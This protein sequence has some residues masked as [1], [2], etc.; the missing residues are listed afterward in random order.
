MEQEVNFQSTRTSNSGS[1]GSSNNSGGGGGGGS[2]MMFAPQRQT[3]IFDSKYHSG[4]RDHE[5][6]RDSS[7]SPRPY[8][9]PHR[10]PT[11]DHS[12]SDHDMSSRRDRREYSAGSSS[13]NGPATVVHSAPSKH[14][15]TTMSLNGSYSSPSVSST[16]TPSTMSPMH[17][18]LLLNPDIKKEDDYRLRAPDVD[19]KGHQDDQHRRRD[20]ERERERDGSGSRGGERDSYR[21]ERRDKDRESRGRERERQDDRQDDRRRM[22]SVLSAKSEV[23]SPSIMPGSLSPSLFRQEKKSDSVPLLSPL[24]LKENSSES[25][26][27]EALTKHYNQKLEAMQN[28]IA[29]KDVLLTKYRKTLLKLFEDKGNAEESEGDNRSAISRSPSR[30]PSSSPSRSSSESRYSDSDMSDRE[31]RPRKKSLPGAIMSMGM[32]GDQKA[33]SQNQLL[34]QQQQQ[35]IFRDES[36]NELKRKGGDDTKSGGE[37][38]PIKKRKTGS[39]RNTLWSVEDDETF[40]KAYNKHGKSWKTIHSLL[41][42][43]TREQVQSHGQYL[44]RIGKLADLHKDGRRTRH[45]KSSSGANSQQSGS[46][47]HHHSHSSST[48]HH[49]SSSGG[50]GGSGLGIGSSGG[51]YYPNGGSSIHQSSQAHY[52]GTNYFDQPYDSPSSD[53]QRDD[54]D[55]DNDVNIG[56]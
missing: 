9:S 35:F 16:T 30:S 31:Q 11:D 23:H 54:Y 36:V 14:P 19:F 44:I 27:I 4:D 29:K 26:K 56:N 40:A 47:G 3:N 22:S 28:V 46:N 52:G 25:E 5:R 1:S 53:S 8:T 37:G 34:S 42:G 33:I 13:N 41:P 48:G 2:N 24:K 51:N 39:R 12:S 18:S 38:A 55:E 7:P 50:G 21:S 15:T 45:Q 20:R 6:E 17:T 10:S 32:S 43:K 49:S